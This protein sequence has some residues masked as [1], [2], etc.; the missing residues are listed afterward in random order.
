ME[1]ISNRGDRILFTKNSRSLGIQNGMMGTVEKTNRTLKTVTVRI[2]GSDQ[3]K[4]VSLR[5]YDQVKLGYAVTTHKG[6]GMTV[7][8]A[9]VLHQRSDARPGAVL[10]T[11]E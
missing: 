6:Q 1:R 5:D 2:D 7:P 3:T 8:R 4:T 10:C 11:G 9:F